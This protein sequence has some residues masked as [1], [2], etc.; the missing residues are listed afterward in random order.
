MNKKILILGS[1]LGLFSVVIGAFAAHGLR[2]KIPAASLQSFETGVRY[3]MYYAFLL[4]IVGNMDVLKIKIKKII[5]YLVFIGAALFSGSIYLL[6]T[7]TLT[8]I[9]FKVIGF[10]TPLG[11]LLLV[12]A[13]LIML[14]SIVKRSN[15]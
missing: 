1:V 6:A 2:P 13:W 5:F 11:G 7:N 8:S 9:D 4:L 12:I 10:A 15:N 3:Q 14:I